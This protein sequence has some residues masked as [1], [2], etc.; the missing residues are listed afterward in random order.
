MW[1]WH[2]CKE[3]FQKQYLYKHISQNHAN[4]TM[5]PTIVSSIVMYPHERDY[6]KSLSEDL[7]IALTSKY[8][9]N[10]KNPHDCGCGL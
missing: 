3:V 6:V 9:K 8:P 2:V 7:E 5:T 4:L 10:D 1:F